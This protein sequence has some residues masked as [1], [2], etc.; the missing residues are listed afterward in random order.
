VHVGLAYIVNALQCL[1]VRCA[2]PAAQTVFNYIS[3]WYG[4]LY[5]KQAS[6]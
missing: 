4:A 3:G 2:V 6:Y 5:N 1:A